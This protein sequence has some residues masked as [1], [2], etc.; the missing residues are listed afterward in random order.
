MS[1]FQ[2]L[3]KVLSDYALNIIIIDSI[4]RKNFYAKKKI[5]S[6]ASLQYLIEKKILSKIVV[7][8]LIKKMNLFVHVDACLNFRKKK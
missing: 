3:I 6:I 4:S 7:S 8:L 2:T 1:S 5:K